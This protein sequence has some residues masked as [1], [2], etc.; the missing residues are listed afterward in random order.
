MNEAAGEST[1]ADSFRESFSTRERHTH[2]V[3]CQ[4]PVTK[5]RPIAFGL[6]CHT[7]DAE[8]R[9]MMTNA[10]KRCPPR[11]ARHGEGSTHGSRA[12]SLSRES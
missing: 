12:L 8:G 7:Q 3:V 1:F 11:G 2:D 10:P 6:I 9:R 5:G 4:A